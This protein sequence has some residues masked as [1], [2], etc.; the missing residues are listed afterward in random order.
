[1]FREIF[2]PMVSPFRAVPHIEFQ[3]VPS[4]KKDLLNIIKKTI[5]VFFLPLK[6]NIA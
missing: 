5:D 6:C 2:K 1:M 4:E 3:N